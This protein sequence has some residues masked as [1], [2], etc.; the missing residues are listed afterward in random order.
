MKVVIVHK[1]LQHKALQ[2]FIIKYYIIHIIIRVDQHVKKKE[3]K[4]V[5]LGDFTHSKK[6]PSGY[7]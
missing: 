3:V 1:M 5:L 7:D 4:I 2:K 6:L